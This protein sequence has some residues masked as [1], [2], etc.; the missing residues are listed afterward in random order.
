[1]LPADSAKDR[2]ARPLVAA[3]NTGGSDALKYPLAHR[4]L[5][6][7]AL[8]PMAIAP[9]AAAERRGGHAASFG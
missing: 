1:M 2:L 6:L 3:A 8:R 4:S 5:P 7:L 9:A